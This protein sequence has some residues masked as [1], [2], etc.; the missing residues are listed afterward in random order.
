MLEIATKE[1]GKMKRIQ[2]NSP[3]R[4]YLA[5]LRNEM[6]K[7]DFDKLSFAQR[8]IESKNE[9]EFRNIKE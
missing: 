3:S 4:S 5:E 2:S 9:G 7:T 6:G 1:E 8:T